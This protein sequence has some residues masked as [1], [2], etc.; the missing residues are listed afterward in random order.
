MKTIRETVNRAGKRVVTVE[1]G[2]GETL[3][4]VK[5]GDFYKLGYPV[6]DVMAGYIIKDMVRVYWD[7]LEQ[8]WIE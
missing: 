3:L 8:K 1:L 5:Q 7:S 6:E 2:E 4:S